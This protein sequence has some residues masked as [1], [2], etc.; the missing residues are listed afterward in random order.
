MRYGSLFS[1]Y[2]GLDMGVMATL[3][4]SVAWH[5][6]GPEDTETGHLLRSLDHALRRA[7]DGVDRF[8]EPRFRAGTRLPSGARAS[9][10]GGLSEAAS[11]DHSIAAVTSSCSPSPLSNFPPLVPT[12]RKLNRRVATLAFSSPRAARK[13][14]AIRRLARD[15]RTA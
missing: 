7:G 1:G 8:V 12:P 11:G 14:E 10:N 13:M 9:F 4:G 15:P 5:R 3:G 6:A 2:G